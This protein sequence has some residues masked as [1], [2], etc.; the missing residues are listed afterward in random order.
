MIE[1]AILDVIVDKGIMGVML[2]WFMLRIEKKLDTINE[3]ILTK[4][5]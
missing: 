2:V 5:E 3:T 4:L 1:Q